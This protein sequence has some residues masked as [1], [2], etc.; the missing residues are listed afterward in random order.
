MQLTS[1]LDSIFARKYRNL[2]SGTSVALH[3]SCAR[4]LRDTQ[5]TRGG[6]GDETRT[7]DV[8]LGKEVLYH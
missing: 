1:L 2:A 6:A 8:L 4:P 5:R 3:G 7:R